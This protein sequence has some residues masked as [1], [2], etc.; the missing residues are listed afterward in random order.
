MSFEY[1]I[2]KGEC[3]HHKTPSLLTAQMNCS[4]PDRLYPSRIHDIHIPNRHDERLVIQALGQP[5]VRKHNTVLSILEAG[6]PTARP[7]LTSVTPGSRLKPNQAALPPMTNNTILSNNSLSKKNTTSL[8]PRNIRRL[9][10]PPL[11]APAA[12]ISSLF[13]HSKRIRGTLHL[14]KM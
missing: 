6:N 5:P 12:G 4:G 11:A 1:A 10:H 3:T 8:I 13:T 9:R 2:A 14:N 7:N